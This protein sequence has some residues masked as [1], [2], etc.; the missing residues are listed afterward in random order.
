MFLY[1]VVFGVGR[2]PTESSRPKGLLAQTSREYMILLLTCIIVKRVTATLFAVVID[3]PFKVMPYFV[4]TTV[5]ASKLVFNQK[6]FYLL[7][8]YAAGGYLRVIPERFHLIRNGNGHIWVGALGV[9][10]IKSSNLT[11][12][13]GNFNMEGEECNS[14]TQSK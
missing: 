9:N 14:V 3:F 6:R 8:I 10:K 5:K 1:V 13:G 11:H 2:P 4:H 7:A 12:S